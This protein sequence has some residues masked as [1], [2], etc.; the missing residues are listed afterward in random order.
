M[1]LSKEIKK[2]FFMFRLF[3]LSA[4]T[5][6][7]TPCNFCKK[8]TLPENYAK[9]MLF[10]KIKTFKNKNDTAIFFFNLGSSRV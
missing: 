3:K 9:I 5:L 1:F 10:A 8:K 4:L 6:S 7:T 2:N